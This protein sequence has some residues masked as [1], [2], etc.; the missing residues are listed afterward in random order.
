M[1]LTYRPDEHPVVLGQE[2]ARGEGCEVIGPALTPRVGSRC[3]WVGFRGAWRGLWVFFRRPCVGQKEGAEERVFDERVDTLPS[4]SPSSPSCPA[5]SRRILR[6]SCYNPVLPNLPGAEVGDASGAFVV[7]AVAHR[8]T[9]P[10]V[11]SVTHDSGD[12]SRAAS[13]LTMIDGS[14]GRDRRHAQVLSVA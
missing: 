7:P 14:S 4:P 8:R 2:V 6:P 3:R 5:K 11:W 12:T 13:H 9:S 10:H 1:R